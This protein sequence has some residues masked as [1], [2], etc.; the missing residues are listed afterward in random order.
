MPRLNAGFNA[1]ALPAVLAAI[2]IGS[3][4][5]SVPSS[6]ESSLKVS[7]S[8]TAV[9]YGSQVRASGVAPAS[10]SGTV[11]L[12]TVFANGTRTL[13]ARASI[14]RSHRWATA[15]RAKVSGR[16]EATGPAS[17][18][19]PEIAAVSKPV[20]SVRQRLVLAQ[21][22][23][24]VSG[25]TRFQGSVAPAGYRIVDVKG[26]GGFHKRIHTSFD[27]R[28]HFIS[29]AAVASAGVHAKAVA[30][31]GYAESKVRSL[32]AKRF[33]AALASFYDDYGLPVACGGVLGRNQIGVA[34]K[35]LPCGTRL[36]IRY[37]GR[38]INA[39]VID[40][41][42]YIAGREFDLTGAAARALH[43]DGVATIWVSR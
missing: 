16:I 27:G 31:R 26:S 12:F 1:V 33:R 11:K 9:D 4:A 20:L 7:L 39:R 15:F 2:G 30:G 10:T 25:P 17:L 29:S 41:G 8:A 24:R 22:N 36:T 19:A 18:L 23:G 34:H 35:T 37:R 14:S 13:T 38:T 5:A 40:R 3:G 42:P 32:S 28:F 21:A 6:T 43:F